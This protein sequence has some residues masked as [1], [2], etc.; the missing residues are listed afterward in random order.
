MLMPVRRMETAVMEE[1]YPLPREIEGVYDLTVRRLEAGRRYRCYLLDRD[2]PTLFDVGF[3]DTTEE[4][5]EGIESTGLVPERV[6][7]THEDPD[8]TGGLAAVVDEYDVETWAPAADADAITTE[9][10]VEVDHRYE[11]GDEIGPWTAIHCAGH[12][13]GA[14]VLLDEEA[15][16]AVTGDVVFGADVRG[17]PP[18]Y[19]IAPPDYYSDDVAAAERNLENLLGYEFDVALVSHGTAVVEEAS[20]KLERYVQFPG[21]AP[22]E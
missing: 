18:G 3:P 15:R 17:L 19:L 10:D 5:F 8:H 1:I 11:D 16:L 20:E 12:T 9:W 22:V 21:K 2:V 7:I 14:S 6:V 4:L 13:P